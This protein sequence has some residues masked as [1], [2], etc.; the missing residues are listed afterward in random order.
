MPQPDFTHAYNTM[1]PS[2][3]ENRFLDWA[4]RAGR[5]GDLRDYDMRGWWVENKPSGTVAGHMTDKYK[6]PNHPTF[7]NESVY[8]GRDGEKGGVWMGDAFYAGPS[9]KRYWKTDELGTYMKEREPG[10]TLHM[11]PPASDYMNK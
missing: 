9:N 2:D 11:L 7:S 6:K 10:V 4:T 5:K 3:D 8:S 1:L